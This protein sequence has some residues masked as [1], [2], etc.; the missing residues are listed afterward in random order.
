MINLKLIEKYFVSSENIAN[1]WM[2]N[3]AIKDNVL[4]ATN[5][6]I[7]IVAPYNADDKPGEELISKLRELF[8]NTPYEIDN[9]FIDTT[10][11]AKILTTI[12][13]QDIFGN[14]EC[15]TCGGD[16]ETIGECPECGQETHTE[17]ESCGGEGFVSTEEVI[18][19]TFMNDCYC[20]FKY[21]EFEVGMNPVYMF[22]ISEIFKNKKIE[23]R[24]VAETRANWF[25]DKKTH[26]IVMPMH[27]TSDT[28]KENIFDLEKA[29]STVL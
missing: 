12:P 14:K 29:C 23:W 18:G 9:L 22:V 11:V 25:T 20:W 5:G 4:Y 28:P 3:F 27:I 8:K 24:R 19:S 1:E 17:C 6:H 15:P 13:R 26:I 21:K 2:Q 7:A 16:G 10:Q